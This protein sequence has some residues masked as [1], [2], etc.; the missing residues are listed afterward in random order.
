VTFDDL[1]A[2]ADPV[3]F[4]ADVMQ[5]LA[6]YAD[7]LDTIQGQFDDLDLPDDRWTRELRDGLAID[8][9]RTRFVLAVYAAT[10]AHLA[11]DD[12]AAEDHFFEAKV[13]LEKAQEIVA[14]RDRDLHDALGDRLIQKTANRTFYQFGYL[15]MADTLCYWDRE[16]VQVGGILGNT[17]EPTPSCLF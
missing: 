6:T 12:G 14:R 8:R 10:L 1:V 4:D 7:Q 9:V 16:L 11:G 15:F 2:G 13:Q 5:P 3:A 17:S